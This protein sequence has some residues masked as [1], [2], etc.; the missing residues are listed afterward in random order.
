MKKFFVMVAMVALGGL[1]FC[2]LPTPGAKRPCFEDVVAKAVTNPISKATL[3][4]EQRVSAE[5]LRNHP[6]S[7]LQSWGQ[8][9]TGVEVSLNGAE[10]VKFTNSIG[11]EAANVSSALNSLQKAGI[12]ARTALSP[13]GGE[14]AGEEFRVWIEKGFGNFQSPPCPPPPQALQPEE[15]FALDAALAEALKQGLGRLGEPIVAL[16]L[17]AAAAGLLGLFGL[18]KIFRLIT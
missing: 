9:L 15:H 6:L 4:G 5:F 12:Q 17:A 11:L 8:R 18:G 7:L 13:K 14:F 1:A 2:S 10:L 16:T 3:T